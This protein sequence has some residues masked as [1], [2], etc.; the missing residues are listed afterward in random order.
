MA[1]QRR[2]SLDGKRFE[3]DVVSLGDRMFIDERL[4]GPRLA[5]MELPGFRAPGMVIT[6]N[7]DPSGTDGVDLYVEYVRMGSARV[8]QHYYGADERGLS[9]VE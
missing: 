5:R 7:V 9:F 4:D 6:F 2:R 1:R 8:L 3:I